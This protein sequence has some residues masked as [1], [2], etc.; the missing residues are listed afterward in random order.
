MS[1]E[2][3]ESDV[4]ELM[5]E[6]V[7]AGDSLQVTLC[8]SAL[9]DCDSAAWGQCEEVILEARGMAAKHSVD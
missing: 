4:E 2:I 5:Q 3:T 7:E 9:E 8:K 6:A 1:F